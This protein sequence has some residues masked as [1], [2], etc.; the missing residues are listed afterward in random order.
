MDTMQDR[1]DQVGSKLD[2]INQQVRE[3][4]EVMFGEGYWETAH[5]F[6]EEAAV[7]NFLEQI[8][9]ESIKDEIACLSP[10]EVQAI[11]NLEHRFKYTRIA[12]LFSLSSKEVVRAVI[13][14]DGV[15][16]YEGIGYY[17][18]RAANEC[19]VNIVDHMPALP[20]DDQ[21]YSMAVIQCVCREDLQQTREEFLESGGSLDDVGADWLYKKTDS[22]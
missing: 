22:K 13:N 8:D 3:L 4:G 14:G 16:R 1:F 18:D 17:R 20:R 21:A 19:T 11:R 10:R 9:R 5:K 2:N 15:G 6:V 12:A 7:D